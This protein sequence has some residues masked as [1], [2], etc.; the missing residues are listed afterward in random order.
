MLTVSLNF[1]Y[2][3]VKDVLCVFNFPNE[4]VH[5]DCVLCV[6]RNYCAPLKR[7]HCGVQQ[8]SVEPTTILSDL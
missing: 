4:V 5:S 8:S 2:V 7:V 6:I 1:F 3:S